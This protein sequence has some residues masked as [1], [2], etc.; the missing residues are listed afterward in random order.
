MPAVP[1]AEP[2]AA[3]IVSK[4][5]A[6]RLVFDE[7]SWVEVTD[8][9]GKALLSQ[10]NPR[11]TEQGVNGKPPFAIVIGRASGVHLYYKGQAVSLV[12]HTKADVAHLTLE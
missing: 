1:P 11:G 10:L 12:P 3:S 9:D 5:A 8:K 6:I 4:T 7:E 2:A